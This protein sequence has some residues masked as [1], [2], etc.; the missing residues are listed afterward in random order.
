MI[1]SLLLSVAIVA[2]DPGYSTS[3]ASHTKRWLQSENIPSRIITPKEMP[4]VLPRERIAF[5]IGFS[6]DPTPTE[7]SALRSFRARGGKLVVFYS[8]SAKLAEMMGVKCAGYAAAP[9]AGAWSRMDFIGNS[10]AGIPATIRQSSTVLMRIRPVP[11]KSR[12]LATWTDRVG[13]ATGEPAWIASGAGYWMSHVLL[14]D[15]EE[16]RKAQLVAAFVGNAEPKLWNYKSH[17][18]RKAAI[19]ART[20]EVA[21]R[22]VPRK[23]E[24]HAVW[25][26]TGQGLYPGDW[27]KTFRTL[28]DAHVTDLY[29][30]IAGAG[31]AHYPSRILPHSKVC[32]QEGDQLSRC[33][34]AAKGTGIRVHAWILCFSAT[35]A[36]SGQLAVFEKK[37]WLLKNASGKTTEYLNPSLPAVRT[38]LLSAI[39]EI[40]KNYPVSG[41]HLDF[42]RWGEG[43]VRPKN[44]EAY[45]TRFVSEARFKVRRPRWLTAAVYGKHPQCVNSVGQ[46]WPAWIDRNF[47]DYVVPMNYTDSMQKLNELLAQQSA[48]KGHAARTIVGIGVTA[49]ESRLDALGVINQINLTRRY[50]FAGNSL[51]DL[52][53]HLETGVLSYLKLGIW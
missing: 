32:I 4:S 23:G 43:T 40:Q 14:S 37:G 10:P 24:I 31:F 44:A 16:D 25:D 3:L 1:A 52:D 7:M 53:T 11:G 28:K 20:R 26:H 45:V 34:A 9:Y 46:D 38:Y 27:S 8:S 5:L 13:K 29:V 22:Q 49:N 47:V 30:N 51:F 21:C 19:H 6:S 42:V 15:G 12:T 39:D 41:I 36:A 17:L 18:A 33:L 2:H 48:R 50:G 35:R